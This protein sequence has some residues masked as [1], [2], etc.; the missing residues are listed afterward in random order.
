MT[1]QRRTVTVI[2]AGTI[3]LGWI[4][5]FLG[6]GMRVRVNSRRPEAPSAVRRGIEL[7]APFLPEGTHDPR[8]FDSL[9]TFEPD[10]ERAVAGA[11]VVVENIPENLELKREL[12]AR[13]GKAAGTGALILSSTSTFSPDDLGT[14]MADPSR[15][16]VGHPFNPPHVVPLV[17]VVAGEATDPAA[18]EDA[19]AFY[20]EAGRT[21]VVLRRPILAFA[22][23][24]LQSALLRE[25]VHLVREGVVTVQELDEVVTSSIGLR[26]ATVGPF[27]AFHLGGGEGGL[28]QW[29]NTLGAGLEQGWELLGRPPMDKDTIATLIAQ[30]DD[31]FGDRS[32]DELVRARDTRQN[33][34]LR[35]LAAANTEQERT[36]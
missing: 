25:S 21:P 20:R 27:L 6:H 26:W 24:R 7:F 19:V 23:N 16:V 18:V 10:L 30:A 22:A 4:T 13:I 17:E 1:Q 28:R 15:L 34:V 36:P 5:L 14:L 9:L 35:A 12:F 11:D 8:T 32:Y 33:A 29:L 31:A 3:G 2:G